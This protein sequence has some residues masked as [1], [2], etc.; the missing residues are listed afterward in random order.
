MGL[1]MPRLAQV[2]H[3]F[4]AARFAAIM[5]DE[6]KWHASVFSLADVLPAN[7][8]TKADVVTSIL[9][10]LGFN[11]H[12]R[13]VFAL[14]DNLLDALGRTEYPAM[15]FRLP[16]PSFAVETDERLICVTRTG[17]SQDPSNDHYSVFVNA[18]SASFGFIFQPD[19]PPSPQEDEGCAH[20]YRALASL[21]VWLKAHPASV[22]SQQGNAV[23]RIIKKAAASRAP[24]RQDVILKRITRLRPA[25]HLCVDPHVTQE[26]AEVTRGEHWVRGHWRWQWK[27]AKADERQVLTWVRPHV[28]CRGKGAIPVERKYK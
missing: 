1:A 17:T 22:T 9:W 28:R 25:A 13:N 20:L 3:A 5:D 26:T 4:G 23:E 15:E 16:Y 6:S 11:K 2:V 12:G 7:D 24:E 19:R 14:S 27:G 21:S 10:A 8:A 18:P